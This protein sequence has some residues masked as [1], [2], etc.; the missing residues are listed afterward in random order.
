M[1]GRIGHS[2]HEVIWAQLSKKMTKRKK[3]LKQ[4]NFNRANYEE[5]RRQ[6]ARKDW[7]E[8]ME[9]KDADGMWEV[10]KEELNAIIEEYVPWK[11]V[12]KREQP[13][14]FD[15]EIGKTIQKRKNAWD[16]W[17][18]DKL[19]ADEVEYKRWEREV[20]QKIK[21]KKN[22]L[23]RRIAKEAKA[24]PKAFYSYV[25]G[26]KR[27]RNKIG[28]L[29]IEKNGKTEVIVEPKKQAEVLNSFF[30]S[31]FTTSTKETPTLDREDGVPELS[32]VVIEGERIR[33]LIAGMK[34]QSAP[35]PDGFPNKLIKEVEKEIAL[36]LKIL[37]R[38]SMDSG[39]IPNDWRQAVF[40]PIYKMKG[41][42]AS[43]GNYRPVSLTSSIG[44]LMERLVKG[45]IEKHIENGIMR[46][47]QH[48]FRGG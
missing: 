2:D 45:E 34:E 41:S 8:D 15:K 22:G 4:Q 25:N 20:K 40:T 30:S 6:L 36:P 26:N 17:K 14:W 37:F 19:V 13:R 47:S 18:K 24:N 27:T 42:K 28:P 31:V 38:N 44:K 33:N 23:E 32:D 11:K 9:G 39:K 21:N 48:G 10:I 1:D 43:P 12:S 46:N 5:A 7:E 29:K 3:G 16:K 35:G